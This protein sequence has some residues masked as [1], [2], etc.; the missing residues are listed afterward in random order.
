MTS[1]EVHEFENVLRD[2]KRASGKKRPKSADQKKVHRQRQ[3]QVKKARKAEVQ[4]AF[5]DLVAFLPS[6]LPRNPHAGTNGDDLDKLGKMQ[7]GDKFKGV[8]AANTHPQ[9]MSDGFFIIN[10]DPFQMPGVH[11]TAVAG[12]PQGICFYDSYDRK[13]TQLFPEVVLPGTG[14]N[15]STAQHIEES[16]CGERCIAWLVCVSEFGIKAAKDFL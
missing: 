13:S 3:K 15:P 6:V 7:F 14:K 5:N 2:G 8:F 9:D 11:W 12:T 1:E 16:N 4:N 10:T